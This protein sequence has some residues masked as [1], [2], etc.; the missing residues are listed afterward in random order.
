MS[1]LM[2]QAWMT[3]AQWAATAKDGAVEALRGEEGQ[4]MVE[5]ALILGLVCVVAIVIL[6]TMGN[7]VNNILT[8]VSTQLGTSPAQGS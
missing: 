3:V 2:L 8:N 4:G 6:V 5:Y 7:Q 1:D